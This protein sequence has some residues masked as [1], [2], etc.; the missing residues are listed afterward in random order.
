MWPRQ[1]L[2]YGR[3]EDP[4]LVGPINTLYIEAWGPL[5]NF[6][7]PSMK[8]LKKWR[9][10][11]RWVRRHDAPQTAYQ[12]LLAHEVLSIKAKRQLRDRYESLDPF[13]LAGDVEKRLKPILKAAVA[14]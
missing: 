2:G 5:H 6:F 3:L 13:A 4:Q 7:L 10:G 14:E 9:V 12:R 11:S 8:L 1:L